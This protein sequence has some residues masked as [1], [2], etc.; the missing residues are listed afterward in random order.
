MPKFIKIRMKDLKVKE[1][2]LV[3][4]WF[5]PKEYFLFSV[6]CY[7]YYNYNYNYYFLFIKACIWTKEKKPLSCSMCLMSSFFLLSSLPQCHW[8]NTLHCSLHYLSLCVCH[9]LLPCFISYSPNSCHTDPRNLSTLYLPLSKV[10]VHFLFC[11]LGF[12]KPVMALLFNFQLIHYSVCC[13][14]DKFCSSHCGYILLWFFLYVRKPSFLFFLFFNLL[15]LLLL[16]LWIVFWAIEIF[17]WLMWN[18]WYSHG[19]S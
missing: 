7:Y 9:S 10:L 8:N 12:Q 6:P 5:I 15:L 17:Y 1:I 3:A 18:Q 13:G 16:D 14:G 2:E 11:W 4:S 19:D